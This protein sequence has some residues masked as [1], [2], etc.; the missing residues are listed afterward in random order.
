MPSGE[1]FILLDDARS[2]GAF[3]ARRP[4]E[5]ARVLREA[6]AARAMHGG[7]LAGYIAYEAGLALE[8]KLATLAAQRTGG[9]G[10][11]VWFGLFDK[12]TTIPAA[13]VPPWL[14]SRAG[15][16]HASIGPLEPQI[17]PGA[18]VEAFEALQ[19]AIR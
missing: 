17:T 6:E 3:D 2:E 1:P 11:L 9:D 16:G 13:E 12:A 10:P 4:D 8:P 7:T 18:Y 15:E 5:V 19:E 14:A